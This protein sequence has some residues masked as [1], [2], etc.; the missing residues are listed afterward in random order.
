MQ[1]L[2]SK[3]ELA[4]LLGCSQN[5]I[6]NLVK[7]DILPPPVR[8]GRLL[9]WTPEQIRNFISDGQGVEK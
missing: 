3:K 7:R 5:T 8:V 9:R 1:R 4:E 2:I 6:S